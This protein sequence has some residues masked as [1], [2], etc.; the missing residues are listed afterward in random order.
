MARSKTTATKPETA[1]ADLMKVLLDELKAQG[2][3]VT[4]KWAP[5]KNYASLL[6]G[7]TN[8]GYV[9]KQTSRGMRIEPAASIADLPKGTKGW[10]PGTRSERFALVGQVTTEAEAKAA[11]AVL[12][13]T[14][15][16]R[17]AAAAK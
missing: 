11:A 1:A 14:D 7:G 17:A 4:P 9:F 15:A 16:K 13:A 2:V 10:K 12:K 6:V 3:K 8:I 5:S